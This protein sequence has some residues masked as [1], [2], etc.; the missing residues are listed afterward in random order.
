LSL[1]QF[2]NANLMLLPWLNLGGQNVPGHG[3][4]LRIKASP[5]KHA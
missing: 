5:I 2:S 3:G 1:F 4:L